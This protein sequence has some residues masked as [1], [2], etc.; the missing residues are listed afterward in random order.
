MKKVLFFAAALAI[1]LVSS[2]VSA[3]VSNPINAIFP[4]NVHQ[5][6]LPAVLPYPEGHGAEQQSI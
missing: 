2:Y 5:L 1:L 6:L 3:Q 4:R